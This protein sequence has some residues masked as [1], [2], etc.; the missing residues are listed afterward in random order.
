MAVDLARYLSDRPV[1]SVKHNLWKVSPE[2]KKAFARNY[3]PKAIRWMRPLYAINKHTRNIWRTDDGE[4]AVVKHP[5]KKPYSRKRRFDGEVY[6]L[7]DNGTF[8]A[9]SIFAGMFNHYEMGTSLGQPTGNLASFYA[10]PIMW[11]KLPNS[12]IWF[13]V[14]TSYQVAPDG[15]TRLEAVHPD[16]E[17]SPYVDLVEYTLERIERGESFLESTP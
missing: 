7:I 8:S 17:V 5:T 3:I 12:A 1:S 16:V 14:S 11:S 13:Q 15:N 6:M 9:G 10:D 2:F 4:N